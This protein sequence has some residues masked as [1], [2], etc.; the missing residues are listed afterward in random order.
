[1][2]A[3]GGQ[4]GV[5]SARILRTLHVPIASGMTII[6]VLCMKL[7]AAV[8]YGHASP[9]HL[10]ADSVVA[11]GSSTQHEAHHVKHDVQH[12]VGTRPRQYS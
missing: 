9:R 7:Q 4:Q 2:I 8:R 11:A 12:H 5:A 1:M 3:G 10:S 6:M